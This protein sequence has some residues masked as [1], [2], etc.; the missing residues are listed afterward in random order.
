MKVLE[1]VRIGGLSVLLTGTLLG[2]SG[3]S[4]MPA[5]P[6]M[7]DG[8]WIPPVLCRIEAIDGHHLA[9][10]FDE[11]AQ[12]SAIRIEPAPGSV[13]DSVWDSQERAI[14]VS[15]EKPFSAGGEYHV[16]AE[17]NDTAGNLSS[18]VAPFY[19]PNPRLPPVL[20]NEI[21]CEGS[22]AHPDWVELR[23]L[24]EGNLGGLTLSEGGPETWESR[25]ILP[26]I[27]VS[28]DSYVIV[29]FKP[30]GTAEEI[31]ESDD[32]AASGGAD[33]H[34]EAWDL[35]VVGGDG[36]PNSTGGLTLSAWPGGP[37]VDAVLY[38]TKHYVA[39]DD[40]RGFGLAS[41][42]AIFEDI[43]AQDGWRIAGEFVVPDDGF[44]PEDS[45]ATRSINRSIDG[46]DTD[47]AADWHIVPTSGATP[48][49]INSEEVYVP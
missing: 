4:G 16:I 30:E 36:I 18:F 7:I 13:I 33:N 9:L 41:Q 14:V 24:E 22:S 44:N 34:P 47:T 38:T 42:L 6:E 48:G 21:V 15:V 39:D 31:S 8:D 10:G 25:C 46:A 49:S 35:W 28:D 5:L 17:V 20:I 43:V 23:V 26:Q 2:C 3:C 32:P 19:G 27:E 1:W 37:V 12:L 40:L 45:T 11:E 29:H